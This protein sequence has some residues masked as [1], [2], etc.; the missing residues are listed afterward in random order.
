MNNR[1][2]GGPD[3]EDLIE[4]HARAHDD[5]LDVA[6]SQKRLSDLFDRVDALELDRE[7][8]LEVEEVVRSFRRYLDDKRYELLELRIYR[9]VIFAFSLGCL[10]FI[11]VILFYELATGFS[12]V[13]DKVRSEIVLASFVASCLA[14]VLG[15]ILALLRGSFGAIRESESQSILPPHLQELVELMRKLNS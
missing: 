7:R 9:I 6:A 11:A 3:W 4:D 8:K 1:G 13:G 15:L 12:I 14:F 10:A 5:N 2:G